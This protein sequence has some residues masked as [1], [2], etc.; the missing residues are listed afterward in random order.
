MQFNIYD[1][2]CLSYLDLIYEN[3]TIVLVSIIRVYGGDESEVHYSLSREETKKLLNTVSLDEFIRICQKRNT[4]LGILD[5]FKE[6]NITYSPK[7]Y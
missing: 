7:G 1:H 6:N 3:E 2:P 5:Y 4:I